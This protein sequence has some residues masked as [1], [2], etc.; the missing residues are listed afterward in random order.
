MFDR[1]G[2]TS[3]KPQ[4]WGGGGAST[5]NPFLFLYVRGLKKTPALLLL[6]MLLVLGL[7]KLINSCNH[8]SSPL[9]FLSEVYLFFFRFIF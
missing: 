4:S 8:F 2:K 3:E 7:R 1:Q 9:L 6:R 5:I